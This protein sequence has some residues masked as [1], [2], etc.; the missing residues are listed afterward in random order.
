MAAL[1]TLIFIVIVPGTAIVLGPYA[2]LSAIG[3]GWD[4]E[5]GNPSTLG[6]IP[7]LLG[8]VVYLWCA[9]DFVV[10]GRGTPAPIDPPRELVVRG[11]VPF[12]PESN[13]HRRPVRA[14]GGRQRCSGRRRC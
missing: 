11:A 2:L 14:A 5:L 7:I 1:K 10:A 13:V 12:R 3:S 6:L 9:R 4:L 8:V